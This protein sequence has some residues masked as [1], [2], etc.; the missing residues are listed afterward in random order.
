[1]N[2]LEDI[3]NK[4]KESSDIVS[5]MVESSTQQ[6]ASAREVQIAVNSVD[7]SAEQ[8]TAL[9]KTNANIVIDME[10][11]TEKLADLMKFFSINNN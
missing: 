2:A 10:K 5:Q 4:A 11:E 8:N 9:V 3:T 7:I 1:M 6:D